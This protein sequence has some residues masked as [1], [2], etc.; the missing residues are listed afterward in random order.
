MLEKEYQY[1]KS[2]EADLR[3]TYF[4]RCI[5][6][7][8]SEVIGDYADK[9]QAIEATIAEGHKPGSFLVQF[10]APDEDGQVAMFHSRVHVH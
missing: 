3:L 4:G 5:V 10:V 1:Y 6:I 2:H 7:K 8:G 9:R